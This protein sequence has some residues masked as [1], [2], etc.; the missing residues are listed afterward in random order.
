MYLIDSHVLL[1]WFMEPKKL[2]LLEHSTIENSGNEIYISAAS[3]W[4]IAIKCGLSKLTVPQNFDAV[5]EKEGFK[6]LSIDLQTAWKVKDLPAH[7]ND[8]FDRLIIATA[9]QEDL[10]LITHDEQFKLYGV[11]ILK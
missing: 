2:T 9:I 10:T 11:K 3:M 6:V 5:L 4:E 7:H 8:P 1:W